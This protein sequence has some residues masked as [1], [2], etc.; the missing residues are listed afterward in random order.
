[1]VTFEI[2]GVA[3]CDHRV[4]HTQLVSVAEVDC[5]QSRRVDGEQAEVVPSSMACKV[6]SVGSVAP[7]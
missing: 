5:L 7:R 2:E 4:T 6:A 1:M 3:H